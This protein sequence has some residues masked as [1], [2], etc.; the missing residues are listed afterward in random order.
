M[1]TAEPTVARMAVPRSAVPMV[2]QTEDMTAALTAAP[3][4]EPMV[5]LTVERARR[6]RPTAAP[7]A[8]RVSPTAE[9]TVAQTAEPV[10]PDRLTT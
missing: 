10:V 1:I 2:A 7:R 6:V 3:M 9:P 8:C 5:E 4:V